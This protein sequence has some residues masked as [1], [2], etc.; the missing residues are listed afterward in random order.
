MPSPVKNVVLIGFMGTGKSTVGKLL[1]KSFGYHFVD[2]DDLIVRRAGKPIPQIFEESG[3]GGFREIERAVLDELASEGSRIIS[4]GG[5]IVTAEDNIE[6]L[7]E[8]GTVVWLTA[9]EESIWQRVGRSRGRPLLQTDD[10]RETI[11]RLLEERKP[12]YEKAA[13]ITVGTDNLSAADI[14]FGIAECLR[15]EAG[16][17]SPER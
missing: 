13:H 9:E 4:T 14:A 11:H 1:A 17:V 15:A 8:L 5:G 7:R 2:T 3:E 16:N 6:R 10:P 12:L